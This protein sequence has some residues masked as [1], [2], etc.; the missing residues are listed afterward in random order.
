[1][2]TTVA[3]QTGPIAKIQAALAETATELRR[4]DQRLDEHLAAL[5]PSAE[6]SDPLLDWEVPPTMEAELFTAL[7][8]IRYELLRPLV[9]I[10][11]K[12]SRITLAMVEAEWAQRQ[13]AVRERRSPLPP[14][15]PGEGKLPKA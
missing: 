12:E 8:Y 5:P 11:E 14:G 2:S 13:K 9:E 3:E 1:M 6:Y 4:I 15:A 10:C 7:E